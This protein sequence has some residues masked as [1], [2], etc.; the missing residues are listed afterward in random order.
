[1]IGPNSGAVLIP[2]MI[3]FSSFNR[4]T[5][6]MFSMATVFSSGNSGSLQ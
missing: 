1:M 3:S 2:W 5:M 4:P 6:S